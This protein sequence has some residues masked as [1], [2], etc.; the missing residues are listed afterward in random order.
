VLTRHGWEIYRV[1]SAANGTAQELLFKPD[2]GDD[3]RLWA[4]AWDLMSIAHDS[5]L[6]GE[7]AVQ[8]FVWL[9]QYVCAADTGD[10][11]AYRAALDDGRI[12]W[13]DLE[14]TRPDLVTVPLLYEWK[15]QRELDG[16]PINRNARPIGDLGRTV[17]FELDCVAIGYYELARRNG[18]AVTWLEAVEHAC[19]RFPRLLIGTKA[20]MLHRLQKKQKP[21]EKLRKL[22]QG[23]ALIP[24][25]R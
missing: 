21:Q 13:A 11:V 18:A 16:L 3:A 4:E 24:K 20:E 17:Q 14:K 2:L 25:E 9:R 10:A 12:G 23:I 8:A 22:Q 5:I 15:T 6:G 7:G 19:A 1:V